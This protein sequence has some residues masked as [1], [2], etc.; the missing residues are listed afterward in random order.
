[1]NIFTHKSVGNSGKNSVQHSAYVK[2]NWLLKNMPNFTNVPNQKY[3]CQ[4]PPN[5]GKFQNFD[6][7]ICQLATLHL[8]HSLV[9]TISDLSLLGVHV[10]PAGRHTQ[11]RGNR[12]PHPPAGGAPSH[13]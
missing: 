10:S 6:I 4:P 7:K 1:M 9:V 8:Y 5:Y 3:L 13:V 2:N 12:P 11:G